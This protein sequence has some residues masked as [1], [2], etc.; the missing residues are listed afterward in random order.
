MEKGGGLL[1]SDHRAQGD[2]HEIVSSHPFPEIGVRSSPAPEPKRDTPELVIDGTHPIT[3]GLAGKARFT[4]AAIEHKGHRHIA[5]ERRTFEP[6]PKGPVLVRNA[7]GDPVLVAGQ[8]GK[9]RVVLVGFFYGR[10]MPVEG[11]KRQVYE[12]ALRWLAGMG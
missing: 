9:G 1:L 12:G 7:F 3:G 2:D 4:P 10:D 8:V 11:V 6:G 5:Y